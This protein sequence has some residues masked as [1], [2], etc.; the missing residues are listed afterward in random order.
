MKGVAGNRKE[1]VMEVYTGLVWHMVRYGS[2]FCKCNRTSSSI[3]EK[4]CSDISG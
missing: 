4:K 1:M 3:T 2:E